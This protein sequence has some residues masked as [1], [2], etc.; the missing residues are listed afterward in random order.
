VRAIFG[1]FHSAVCRPRSM[2]GSFSART[3]KLLQAVL[4][5]SDQGHALVVSLMSPVVRHKFAGGG[6]HR[7]GVLIPVADAEDASG[8]GIRQ[9]VHGVS[10]IAPPDRALRRCTNLFLHNRFPKRHRSWHPELR[11]SAA[12]PFF[13]GAGAAVCINSQ[14]QSFT[15]HVVRERLDSRRKSCGIATMVPDASRLT[16]QQSSMF[17]YW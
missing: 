9:R 10:R 7:H 16:C 1:P 13:A 2:S 17:T 15:V 3:R 11:D 5:K 4:S 14:L 6:P 12:W 8:D